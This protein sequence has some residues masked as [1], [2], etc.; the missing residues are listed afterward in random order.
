M[1]HFAPRRA[2]SMMSCMLV[3]ELLE[4][5]RERGG[6]RRG[7]RGGTGLRQLVLLPLGGGTICLCEFGLRHIMWLH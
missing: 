6:E 5:R 2:M 4:Q 7:N 3:K 1:E